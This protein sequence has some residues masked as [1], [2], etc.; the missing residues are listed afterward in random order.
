MRLRPRR[1]RLGP[2]LRN[3][4]PMQ[5]KPAATAAETE[6]DDKRGRPKKGS[7]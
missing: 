5:D 6:E 3:R 4:K 7:A 1:L 2:P